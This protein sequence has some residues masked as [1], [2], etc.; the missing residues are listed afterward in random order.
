MSRIADRFA[1]LRER[2]EKALIPYITAGD[3]D[4]ATTEALVEELEAAGA[5]IV[6]LGAPFSDPLV[7]GAEIQRASQR[8][9]KSGANLDRSFQPGRSLRRRREMPMLVTSADNPA[10]RD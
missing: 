7:D 9:L 6:A 1:R 5:D 8:G 3:P 10:V 2:G 4:L